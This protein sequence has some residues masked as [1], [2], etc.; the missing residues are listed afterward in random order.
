MLY[1]LYGIHSAPCSLDSEERAAHA[2]AVRF[3]S[4]PR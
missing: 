1:A 4:E 3:A 2:S